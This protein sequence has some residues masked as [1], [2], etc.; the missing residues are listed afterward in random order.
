MDSVPGASCTLKLPGTDEYQEALLFGSSV[1]RL[2]KPAG[3]PIDI[4]GTAPGIIH[5]EGMV[6]TGS[7]GTLVNVKRVKVAGT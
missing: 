6:L 5:E 4:Q 3:N 1:W 7:D 2:P